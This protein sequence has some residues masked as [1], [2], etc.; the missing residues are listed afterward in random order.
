[1]T[2]VPDG[3]VEVKAMPSTGRISDVFNAFKTDSPP[4]LSIEEMNEI[5][6][7]GWAGKK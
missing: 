7:R 2:K 1:M 5:A 4:V 3:K 6:A